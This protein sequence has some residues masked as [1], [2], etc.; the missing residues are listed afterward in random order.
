[1]VD[2]GEGVR[3]D[4]GEITGR[5]S[6]ACS[7]SHQTPRWHGQLKNA[8]HTHTHTPNRHAKPN[9]A[10]TVRMSPCSPQ[11]TK[12]EPRF[13]NRAPSSVQKIDKIESARKSD[14]HTQ[15]LLTAVEI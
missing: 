7:A 13:W 1:M 4:V 14:L 2:V 10:N 3:C 5:I 15:S 6:F 9:R 12:T 8:R 11:L